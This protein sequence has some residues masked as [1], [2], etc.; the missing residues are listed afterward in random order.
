[1]LKILLLDCPNSLKD[2]LLGQGFDVEAGTVGMC[3]GVRRLPSQVYEKDLIFYS[4]EIASNLPE[5][6]GN[7]QGVQSITDETPYFPFSHLD[8]RIKAGATF[9]AF[10]N[11]V[12][13]ALSIQQS[14]YSWV[15]EMPPLAFTHDKLIYP[16]NFKAYPESEFK[17]QLAGLVQIDQLSIPALI[18]LKPPEYKGTPYSLPKRVDLFRNGNRDCLGFQLLHGNGRIFFLPKFKSNAETIELFLHRIVPKIYKVASHLGLVDL[19]RSPSEESAS[20]ELNRLLGEEKEIIEQQGVVRSALAATIRTK[21]KTIDD[22]ETAKQILVYYD[23]ARRQDDV[24]LYFLYKI[25]EAIENKLGGEAEGIKKLGAGVE[26]KAV[27]RLANESY[28]DARHA[29]KPG[30]VVRKWTQ[31]EIKKCFANTETIVMAYFGTLF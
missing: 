15:P 7:I 20:T 22:D 3:T 16:C 4:P 8:S 29:P 23:N 31:D 11:P 10:I 28:R 9:I 1:M 6:L 25:V 18:K 12:S 13:K 26:W 19:F 30:D 5:K 17:D 24:A 21:E 27:K 14:F 2:K